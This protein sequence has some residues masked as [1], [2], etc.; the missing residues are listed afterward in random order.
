MP[1]A[2]ASWYEHTGRLSDGSVILGIGLGC[3]RS[4]KSIVQGLQPDASNSGV[5][6]C[7]QQ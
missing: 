5:C 6:A 7:W 1:Q 3:S 2:G 4:S